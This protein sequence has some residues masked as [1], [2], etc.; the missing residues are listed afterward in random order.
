[1]DVGALT[2]VGPQNPA[3][4]VRRRC[5]PGHVVMLRGDLAAS[6]LGADDRPRFEALVQTIPC[7]S[8]WSSTANDVLLLRLGTMHS[9]ISVG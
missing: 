9:I 4:S 8:G 1:V 3:R 2:L 5:G 7:G 6:T